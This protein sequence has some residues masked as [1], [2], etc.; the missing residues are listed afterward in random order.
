MGLRSFEKRLERMVEGTFSRIFRSGL[1]PVEL[2]RRL[3]REMEDGR[4]VGVRGKTIVPNYFVVHLSEED[5]DRFAEVDESLS[6][7]LADAAREHAADEGYR[8]MG[9]V[10]VVLMGDPSIR[11]GSFDIAA[12]LKEGPGG[13]GPGSLV[14]PDGQ[15]VELGSDPVV[16]G[17]LG[18]CDIAVD[19][20]NVSREHTEVRA[21]GDGYVVADL[22]STNGTRVNDEVVGEVALVDGDVIGIGS[23]SLRF[24]AS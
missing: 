17:R 15:R 2:G 4:S 1:R 5:H 13:V 3:I 10:Q 24:E 6:R 20:R 16:I 8:F 23:L 7:E 19:D 12:S 18:T 9:P 14:L 21:Q 11:M 22:G